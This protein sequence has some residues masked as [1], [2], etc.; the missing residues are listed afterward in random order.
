MQ[1]ASLRSMREKGISKSDL[2]KYVGRSNS[3]VRMAL[4]AKPA[5]NSLTLRAIFNYMCPQE[6][7]GSLTTHAQQLA[8]Q[9]PETAALLAALF[10]DLADLLTK[11]SP[12]IRSD[13]QRS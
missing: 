10:R 9:A 12:T 6:K 4:S 5:K 13:K 7:E 2:A 8:A 1:T 3:A 11:S